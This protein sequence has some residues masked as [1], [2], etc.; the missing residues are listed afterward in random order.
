VILKIEQRKQGLHRNPWCMGNSGSKDE[1]NE[2][3]WR[4]EQ[5]GSRWVELALNQ[6]VVNMVQVIFD[7]MPLFLLML[8]KVFW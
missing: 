2:F 7:I 8:G 1:W 5:E 6:M 3:Y 4:W